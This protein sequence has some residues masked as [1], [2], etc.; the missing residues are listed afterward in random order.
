MCGCHL[1]LDTVNSGNNFQVHGT[2][3]LVIYG[4]I[5]GIY[6]TIFQ[7][8]T[9]SYFGQLADGSQVAME[10]VCT[11]GGIKEQFY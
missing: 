1:E 3:Q 8:A 4:I 10:T 7:F 6:R 9:L 2:P 11:D 5:L